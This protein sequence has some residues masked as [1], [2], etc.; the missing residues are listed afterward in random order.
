[1][2]SN[3]YLVCGHRPSVVKPERFCFADHLVQRLAAID[4]HL[5]A[6]REHAAKGMRRCAP[7]LCAG[8]SPSSMS[9]TI[10]ARE[11]LSRSAACCVVS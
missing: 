9:R 5:L 4:D 7:T 8:S 6:V 3:G 10:V 11:T 2:S 1:M